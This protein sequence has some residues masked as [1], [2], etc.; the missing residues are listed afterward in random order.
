MF[1]LCTVS[2]YAKPATIFIFLKNKKTVI[3]KLYEIYDIGVS[4]LIK[5]Y[6]N[7]IKI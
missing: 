7:L 4:K 1:F 2:L 5:M 6:V 3:I